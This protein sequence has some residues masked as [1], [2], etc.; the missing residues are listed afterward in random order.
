MAEKTYYR[1]VTNPRLYREP[2]TTE[3]SRE[4]APLATKLRKG[5]PGESVNCVIRYLAL[6]RTMK[7]TAFSCS[8]P[9]HK[10]LLAKAGMTDRDKAT[11]GTALLRRMGIPARVDSLNGGIQYQD[12]GHWRSVA[13]DGRQPVAWP[14]A[15]LVQKAGDDQLI[16]LDKNGIFFH[17]DVD[18]E[19]PVT[20]LP[21]GKLMVVG[22]K[23][24]SPTSRT[25]RFHSL[26]QTHPL[27]G[28]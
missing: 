8:L 15:W 22:V 13:L 3:W 17:V 16:L 4:L 6:L 10:A 20:Y 23:A 26:P 19:E 28:Q 1:D 27:P 24:T 11:L 25:G 2:L 21:Q 12:G 18:E 7:R 14:T 9:P 5:S